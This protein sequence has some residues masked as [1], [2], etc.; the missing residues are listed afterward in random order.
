M[1]AMVDHRHTLGESGRGYP[2]YVLKPP[3]IALVIVSR[4]TISCCRRQFF[5]CTASTV[6]QVHGRRRFFMCTAIDIISGAQS[7]LYLIKIYIITRC[8]PVHPLNGALP[9]PYVPARITRGTLVAHRYIMHSL[10][11]EL[12]VEQDFYSLFGVPLE[13]SC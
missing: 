4:N 1:A 6:Y 3:K 7:H 2:C 9:G 8:N 12:A 10:A 5:R 13:R 11:A